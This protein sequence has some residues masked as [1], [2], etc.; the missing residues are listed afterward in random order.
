MGGKQAAYLTSLF[1]LHPRLDISCTVVTTTIS[2][3]EG[4]LFHE[5]HISGGQ[6]R[7]AA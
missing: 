3:A 7:V 6:K 1:D 4:K 5:A 2:G